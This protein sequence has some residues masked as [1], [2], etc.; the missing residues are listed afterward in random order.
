MPIWMINTQ[1][2]DSGRMV[3]VG[4]FDGRLM[5]FLVLFFLSP[6]K[7]TFGLCVFSIAFF[8]LLQYMGYTLPNAYRKLRVLLSGKRKN[9]VHYWRQRRFNF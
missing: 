9:G 4:P 2:R 3:V 8:Y 1:W 5:L 7:I 6:G